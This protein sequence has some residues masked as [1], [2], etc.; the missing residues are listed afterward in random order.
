MEA[1]TWVQLTVVVLTIYAIVVAVFLILENRS[2]QSTLAWLPV[3]LLLPGIGLFVYLLTGRTWRAFSHRG[4]LVKV[5]G[6]SNMSARVRRV[7]QTQPERMDQL[8]KLG[9]LEYTRLATLLWNSGHSLLT[10]HNE[11]EILQ[12]ASEKYPRLMGDIEGAKEFVHMLYYEWA[13]DPFT[14]KLLALMIEKVKQGVE[15][16]II[17]DPAGSKGMLSKDYLQR[18]HHA[19]IQMQPYSPLYSIHNI[20]YR[21]HRKVV[22]IDGHVAYAGGLNMTEKHLTGPGAGFT[23]WRDTH[24]RVRGEAA[25]ILQGVFAAMWYNTTKENTFDEKYFPAPDQQLPQLPIQVVSAGPDSQWK[26]IRKCYLTMI[27]LARHH[28]YIQSPFLVLD[29]SMV[30]IAKSAAMSGVDITFMIAPKG[31]E[32]DIAYR[33][34]MTYAKDLVD[35]GVKVMLYQGAYFHAKTVCVDSIMCSIGS[36]NMDIRSFSIDYEA[37]LVIYDP[38]VTE[39]LEQDFAND[40]LSCVPFSVEEYEQRSFG[41]RLSD[42]VKRL[43]SPLL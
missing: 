13:S 17:Y 35:A 7:L 16:R 28:V 39:E 27:K 33:A 32:T 42:S 6:S 2:P 37:N 3:L 29:E 30:E 22:I 18:A 20:S 5:V 36:A 23:G 10:F 24:S 12:D 14:E 38:K 15:I 43:V 9:H 40:L 34:G 11:F 1:V 19:G 25:L 41:G 21:N 26:V 4:E 31:A 8:A